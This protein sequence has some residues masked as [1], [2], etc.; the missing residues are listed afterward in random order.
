MSIIRPSVWI[1]DRTSGFD[2]KLLNGTTGEFFAQDNRLKAW[3][4][5][6]NI[7]H[8]LLFDQVHGAQG[9]VVDKNHLASWKNVQLAGDYLITHHPG[10]GLAIATADCVPIMI[11]HPERPIIGAIHMG[12]KGAIAGVVQNC[13]RN[14]MTQYSTN[15]SALRAEIGPAARSCC[16]EIGADLATILADQASTG[17]SHTVSRHNKIYLD[18]TDWATAILQSQGINQITYMPTNSACTI[19]D[20]QFYS[21]RIDRESTGRNITIIALV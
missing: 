9:M 3:D 2:K 13:L 16:Y 17:L 21:Y 1:A 20:Q 7:S 15:T 14:I 4:A 19:H 6:G 18:M 11:Y 5:I 12:W 8:I 10:I